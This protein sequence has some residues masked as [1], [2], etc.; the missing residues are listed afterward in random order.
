[1]ACLGKNLSLM[2]IRVA[3]ALLLTSFD[4][5]FAPG[6]DGTRMF[7]KATDYFTTTPGPLN[8]VLKN[9]IP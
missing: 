8:L 9:R 2:E 6:E 3:A 7:T 1:M 5:D 4:F